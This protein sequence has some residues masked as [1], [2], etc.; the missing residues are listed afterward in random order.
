M[1]DSNDQKMLTFEG[2]KYRYLQVGAKIPN[3]PVH[4]YNQFAIGNNFTI[5][6]L[7][8]MHERHLDMEMSMKSMAKSLP[9]P[10]NKRPSIVSLFW[11]NEL[12]K[13]QKVWWSV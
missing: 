13:T 10:I 11:A 5:F 2:V 3:N 1:D 7:G 8:I 9:P 4:R 6:R 12:L